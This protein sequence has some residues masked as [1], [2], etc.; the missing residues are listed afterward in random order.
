[1]TQ[2]QQRVSSFLAN[3][4]AD[5][6]LEALN[7]CVNLCDAV[8]TEAAHQSLNSPVCALCIHSCDENEVAIAGCENGTLHLIDLSHESTQLLA[9]LE[10]RPT[11]D[12]V[13]LI[14]SSREPIFAAGCS[15]G[16]VRF[17][18]FNSQHELRFIFESLPC[19]SGIRAVARYK[20][21][22]Y[23]GTQDGRVYRLEVPKWQNHKRA[24]PVEHCAFED[25]VRS[26]VIDKFY[27]EA[28]IVA[29]TYRGTVDVRTLRGRQFCGPA[30]LSVPGDGGE[31]Q[32]NWVRALAVARLGAEQVILAGSEDCYVTAFVLT[33]TSGVLQ[34]IWRYRT[35]AWVFSIAV[36]DVNGDGRNEI[37]AAT[38]DGMLYI[39]S[40][41]GN[42]L[43]LRRMPDRA[44]SARTWR[45]KRARQ[46]T[47]LVGLNNGDV[48]RFKVNPRV[49]LQVSR[50]MRR[51]E[52]KLKVR[53]DQWGLEA[54]EMKDVQDAASVVTSLTCM[55]CAKTLPMNMQ[56][57]K[58]MLWKTLSFL[59]RLGSS[60]TVQVTSIKTN[61]WVTALAEI[62]INED[63]IPEVIAG[64]GRGE[65]YALSLD[66][67][68]VEQHPLH[69]SSEVVAII[70]TP[71]VEANPMIT[72]A[73]SDGTLHPFVVRD[74]HLKPAGQF[75][76]KTGSTIADI[77]SLRSDYVIASDQTSKLDTVDAA[78][79]V[80]STIRLVSPPTKLLAI[81]CAAREYLI[82]GQH[83][84]TICCYDWPPTAGREPVWTFPG[85]SQVKALAYSPQTGLIAGTERGHVFSIVPETGE[86]RW[87]FAASAAITSIALSEDRFAGENGRDRPFILIGSVDSGIYCLDTT[88][89]L[90]WI[91]KMEDWVRALLW[92]GSVREGK[93][94]VMGST[95][96]RI[97]LLRLD[98]NA[99]DLVEQCWSLLKEC[100][101]GHQHLFD[102]RAVPRPHDPF[103]DFL[104]KCFGFRMLKNRTAFAKYKET[105]RA[106]THNDAST[107]R[108]ALIDTLPHVDRYLDALDRD[109]ILSRLLTN[110]D[111]PTI[112]SFLWF[113][114]SSKSWSHSKLAQEIGRLLKDQDRHIRYTAL[115]T[116]KDYV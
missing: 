105:F 18:T 86:F 44:F 88:G 85:R 65:I 39:L 28:L 82:S 97:H 32:N 31:A 45:G 80:T 89:D 59:L 34:P 48:Y 7:E 8:I 92:L 84:G 99:K 51:F 9:H 110:S 15:D 112:V 5:K 41:K 47:M 24:R 37:L 106:M 72:A 2:Q 12:S 54:L 101:F 62:D 71:G 49:E 13:V 16:I 67:T 102:D 79:T 109:Y 116:L 111:A 113:L 33:R 19:P 29:G 17:L 93:Y 104:L 50:A 56:N 94:L 3:L 43:W 36:G 73:S 66:G 30:T 40:D 76:P 11:P 22:L 42:L 115:R 87:W 68:S 58:Q 78:G 108:R 98:L 90:I 35:G 6:F 55:H 27:G 26:L 81:R 4:E 20:N 74:H 38:W 53:I 103:T 52:R 23:L 46:H 91:E 100:G 107:W 14:D 114:R 63:S 64:T 10:M 77:V 57:Y 75:K 96:R 21:N 69:P 1:M 25:G 61:D 70:R 95:D 60:R 83:D